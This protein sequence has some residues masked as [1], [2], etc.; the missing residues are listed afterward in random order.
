MWTWLQTTNT[1]QIVWQR[2]TAQCWSDET[3]A[4]LDIFTFISNIVKLTLVLVKRWIFM[5]TNQDNPPAE[6]HYRN[7]H[8]LSNSPSCVS[9]VY[10]V[11]DTHRFSPPEL[12]LLLQS[13]PQVL[14]EVAV[15]PV[16]HVNVAQLV[17]EGSLQTER[18]GGSRRTWGWHRDTLLKIWSPGCRLTVTLLLLVS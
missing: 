5:W 10:A 2:S 18:T 14:D 12:L 4:A 9:P 16:R 1:E 6:E 7:Q 11:A 13:P 8:H 3:Q 15:L 17:S